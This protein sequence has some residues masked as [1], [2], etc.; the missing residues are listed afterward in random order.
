MTVSQVA[1]WSGFTLARKIPGS[2]ILLKVSALYVI[3]GAN[4]IIS[5]AKDRGADGHPSS[6][7]LAGVH[8]TD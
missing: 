4:N 6:N 1:S 3:P 2:Y 8:L 5:R 7:T